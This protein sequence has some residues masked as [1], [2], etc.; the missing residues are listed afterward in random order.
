MRTRAVIRIRTHLGHEIGGLD[1]RRLG[2]AAGHDHVQ[3]GSPRHQ[4][5]HHLIERQIIVAQ[6]DVEFVEHDKVD[7]GIIEQALRNG[8]GALA[9]RD[10]ARLVL[11]LPGK[12]FPGG[13]PDHAVAERFE[14]R[15]LAGGPTLDEL[16]HAD[17]PAMAERSQ[18]ETE[19]RRGFA[20]A[21]PGV[22]HQQ[23][24]GDGFGRFFGVLDR[25]AFDHL[26]AVPFGLALGLVG[27]DLGHGFLRLY[28]MGG[29]RIISDTSGQPAKV[30]STRF[31][32][33]L[34]RRRFRLNES[35]AD[36]V[37]SSGGTKREYRAQDIRG[38][39][40]VSRE[41]GAAPATVSGK[42]A[43][44]TTGFRPGKV[45]PAMTREPG[46]LPSPAISP[47]RAGRPGVRGLVERSA[48]PL[49]ACLATA[50]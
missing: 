30:R 16:H 47:F 17:A 23:A 19:G 18:R 32:E 48:G 3:I 13:V 31:P 45:V 34:T 21:R 38:S 7:A 11:R 36:G 41:A 20:L 40:R 29:D 26:G 42:P 33:G 28:P 35:L 39:S 8:P 49:A 37:P 2:V 46:N 4:P 25:L 27:I 12:A 6:R 1:H 10:I 5:R 44:K 9:G 14:R 50:R 24:L 43:P 15:L 22:D